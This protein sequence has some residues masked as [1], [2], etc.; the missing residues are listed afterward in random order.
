[1]QVRSCIP[2]IPSA[3]L[4]KSLRLGW[5]AFVTD[6]GG[7]SHCFGVATDQVSSLREA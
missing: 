4:E 3:D 5:R 7:C 1:M 6:D 2:V